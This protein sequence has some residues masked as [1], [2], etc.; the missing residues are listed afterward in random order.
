VKALLFGASRS[1]GDTAQGYAWGRDQVLSLLLARYDLVL[2]SGVRGPEVWMEREAFL[3]GCHVVVF[4]SDG[5]RV[6]SRGKGPSRWLPDTL[7]PTGTRLRDEALAT[8]ASKA[9][10]AGWSVTCVGLLDASDG[11]RSGTAYRLGLLEARG[12]TTHRIFW[13]Q[14]PV[15]AEVAA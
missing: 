9:V 13:G 7:T 10:Q 4:H 15:A 12:L 11:E 2:T 3:W 14:A 6:D 5:R 1:I 8:A